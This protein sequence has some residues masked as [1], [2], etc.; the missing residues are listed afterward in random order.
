[1]KVGAINLFLSPWVSSCRLGGDAGN[2]NGVND[3][4]WLKRQ[5]AEL[6]RQL[7]D[8]IAQLDDLKSRPPLHRSTNLSGALADTPLFGSDATGSLFVLKLLYIVY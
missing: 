8:V 6:Q 4:D 5:N 3:P 2:P 1:M 7:R